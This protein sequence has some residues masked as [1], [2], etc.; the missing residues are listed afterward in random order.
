MFLTNME[1][2]APVL[3]TLNCAYLYKAS[4]TDSSKIATQSAKIARTDSPLPSSSHHYGPPPPP[5]STLSRPN[6]EVPDARSSSDKADLSAAARVPLERAAAYSTSSPSSH[7]G[8]QNF[9]DYNSHRNNSSSSWYPPS[10][11]QQQQQH[12]QAPPPP[13]THSPRAL[14]LSSSAIVDRPLTAFLWDDKKSER[15]DSSLALPPFNAP[16]PP[17]PSLAPQQQTTPA[18]SPQL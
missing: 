2:V 8:L 13:V 5:P 18:T 7:T 15:K 12:Q 11:Y 3:H 10:S 4:A 17:P 9:A 14:A 1:S 16:P 6:D